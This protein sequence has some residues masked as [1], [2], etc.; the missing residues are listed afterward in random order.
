LEG[1][2]SANITAAVEAPNLFYFMY[3]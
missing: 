2:V 3:S 1:T